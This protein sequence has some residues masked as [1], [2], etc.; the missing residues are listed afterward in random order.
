MSK[1][2]NNQI[3]FLKN[4]KSFLESSPGVFSLYS[5]ILDQGLTPMEATPLVIYY[6]E[7]SKNYKLR[8]IR[9]PSVKYQYSKVKVLLEGKIDPRDKFPIFES[10]NF[11]LL[12]PEGKALAEVFKFME[13]RYE[14]DTSKLNSLSKYPTYIGF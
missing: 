2:S 3:E 12:F 5:R 6:A 7:A 13:A 14:I 11:P 8:L 10:T 4:N 9:D 1:L